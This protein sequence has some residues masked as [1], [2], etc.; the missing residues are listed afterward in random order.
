[1]DYFPSS[2]D[3]LESIINRN[4]NESMIINYR[5]NLFFVT[6]YFPKLPPDLIRFK[7]PEFYAENTSGQSKPFILFRQIFNEEYRKYYEKTFIR[8]LSPLASRSWKALSHEDQKIFK[9]LSREINKSKSRKIKNLKEQIVGTCFVAY[10][11]LKNPYYHAIA[12]KGN[13]SAGNAFSLT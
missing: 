5:G 6:Q 11:V 13:V 10:K 8:Q 2:K 7:N 9:D 12:T 4:I 3:V 1:M